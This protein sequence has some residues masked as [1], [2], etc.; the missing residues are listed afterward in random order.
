[1]LDYAT[2]QTEDWLEDTRPGTL[3]YVKGLRLA[4]E[5]KFKVPAKRRKK[6]L[7]KPRTAVALK[8]RNR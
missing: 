6:A 5:A 1:M 2:G 8:R 7:T 3:A 4:H